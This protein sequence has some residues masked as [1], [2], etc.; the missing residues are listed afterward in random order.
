MKKKKQRV[1]ERKRELSNW[2]TEYKK[3]LCCVR[4]GITNHKCLQFHHLKDKKYNVSQ[5]PFNG[6]SIESIKKE[7]SKC[8]VLCA[9]CHSIEHYSG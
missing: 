6:N 2:L 9:N 7:I 5:M 4:C 1:I 8:I 3:Q